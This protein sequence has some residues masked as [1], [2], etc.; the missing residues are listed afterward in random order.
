MCVCVCC[1][2]NRPRQ[3]RQL[4]GE[5]RDSSTIRSQRSLITQDRD[6]SV[7]VYHTDMPN[8]RPWSGCLLRVGD[9][10]PNSRQ[11]GWPV[12][13]SVSCSRAVNLQQWRFSC[14][15]VHKER[16]SAPAY[17]LD[18][19]S[20][21]ALLHCDWR[22]DAAVS[23]RRWRCCSVDWWRHYWPS[24]SS[25]CRH[26]QRHLSPVTSANKVQRII[27]MSTGSNGFSKFFHWQISKEAT[28]ATIAGPSALP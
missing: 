20:W 27:V 12:L 10:Y 28:Y 11:H 19:L 15:I 17:P 6:S 14:L 18:Q 3:R 8:S 2:Y 9:H 25:C 5:I 22:F 1:V 4:R 23:R 7:C 21:H 26:Q 13:R 16:L 24:V